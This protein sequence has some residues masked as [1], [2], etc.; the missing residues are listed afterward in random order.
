MRK[1]VV[2]NKS[3][4]GDGP[5][6]QA[7]LSGG[8]AFVSGQGPLDPRSGEI[9]GKSITEQT[10]LTMENIRNIVEAAGCT[11]D[12]VVKINVFLAKMSDFQAF[13]KVY[14]HFF[15]RPMPA[16][17]CVEAG[18]GGILVEIDAIAKLPDEINAGR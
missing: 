17:S 2:T 12:D 14:E 5:Y 18:L 4:A 6:S 9:V 3:S 8:F 1:A 7:I 13:N 10:Q 16:R 15:G 11:M